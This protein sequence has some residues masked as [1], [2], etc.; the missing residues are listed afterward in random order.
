MGITP[1]DV[2]EKENTKRKIEQKGERER[3][4][5][6]KKQTRNKRHCRQAIS[7]SKEELNERNI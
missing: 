7:K 4:G 3:D 2:A 5:K 6:N 1:H